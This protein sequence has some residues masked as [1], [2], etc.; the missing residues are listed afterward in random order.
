MTPTQDERDDARHAAHELAFADAL[1][2]FNTADRAATNHGPGH[3]AFTLER[4]LRCLCVLALNDYSDRYW[5]GIGQAP[6]LD[7][8]NESRGDE[9]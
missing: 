6:H 4:Y 3:E 9:S 2:D 5:V 7:D 8:P 1:D